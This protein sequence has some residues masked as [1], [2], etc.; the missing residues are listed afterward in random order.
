MNS[1]HTFKN[2]QFEVKRESLM[3]KPVPGNSK[4]QEYNI[5]AKLDLENVVEEENL[6]S[7]N[8]FECSICT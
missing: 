8:K 6:N 1:D 7:I 3:D 5:Y 2:K 4:K